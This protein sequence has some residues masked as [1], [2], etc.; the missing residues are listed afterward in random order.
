MNATRG[1]AP[2]VLTLSPRAGG[3]SDAAAGLFARGAARALGA[4]VPVTHLRDFRVR[5]CTSCH[6]CAGGGPCPQDA[7]DDAGR[8][9]DALAQAPAVFLAAPIYFYHLP[10]QAKALVDRSQRW[11]ERARAGDPA[12]AALA[13]RPAYCCL[14]AG[15]PVGQ[16]LFEGALLTL[17]YFLASFRLELRDPLTLRGVDAPGELAADAGARA[18][19]L[20]M[21]RRAA[22]G[23]DGADAAGN[24][25]NGERG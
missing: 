19:L 3:N 12:V 16:R 13:P 24:D 17:R 20:E 2:L 8:L 14:V 15:R 10:A 11:Y 22:L 1:G 5:P 23:E 25:K 9:L 21:G 4:P 7:G 6:A 18:A